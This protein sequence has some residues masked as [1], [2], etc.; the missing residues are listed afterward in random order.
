YLSDKT[1]KPH[2]INTP[3]DAT[4]IQAADVC[5]RRYGM[6]LRERSGGHDYEG[7]SYRSDKPEPFNVVDLSKMRHVRVD[8]MKAT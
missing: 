3:T 7:L 1:L 2:N 6:R 5:G 8:G 4:H